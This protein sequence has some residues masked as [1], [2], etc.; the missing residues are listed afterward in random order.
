LL[1]QHWIAG[2]VMNEHYKAVMADLIGRKAKLQNELASIE[3]TIDGLMRV[4]GETPAQKAEAVYPNANAIQIHAG[5]PLKPVH[6]NTSPAGN[7]YV[8][9]TLRWSVMWHLAAAH[10]WEK[11]GDI[12]RSL[13]A[14][15]YKPKKEK[16]PIGNLVSA[17]LHHMRTGGDVEVN[18]AGG[19]RLTDQGRTH[20]NLISQSAKFK[21][22]ASGSS[23]QSLLG[24][25]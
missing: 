10:D 21:A 17:A 6:I 3:A 16:S 1:L 9:L 23:A 15:G 22:A 12:A 4:F 19:Y 24:V 5:M 2:V 20:W 8:G 18:E 25:Q 7:Q 14:G 11:T 13:T